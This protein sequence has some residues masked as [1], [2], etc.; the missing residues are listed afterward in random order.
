VGSGVLH[1][2]AE[3]CDALGTRPRATCIVVDDNTHAAAGRMVGELL[4]AAGHDVYLSNLTRHGGTNGTS[5]HPGEDAA[6]ALALDLRRDTGLLLAVGSGTVTDVTRFVAART[7]LPF[8]S[9]ATAPSVDAYTSVTSPM[10]RSGLKTTRWGVQARFVLADTDVLAAAPP[11]LI[12]SGLGDTVAKLVARCDWRLADL[13]TDS[14]YCEEIDR[15]VLVSVHAAVNQSAAIG[16]ALPE[17]VGILAESLMVSGAAMAMAGNTWPASGAEHFISHYLEM[18]A[19]ERN[20]PDHLHGTKVGVASVVTSLVWQR[21]ASRLAA[22]DPESIDADEVWK[23]RRKPG[24][25]GRML[26]QTFGPS[27]GRLFSSN[28]VARVG[29]EAIAARRLDTWKA[30]WGTLC[31]I[32][33]DT[34]SPD[35]IVTWL[36]EAG[37]PALPAEIGIDTDELRAT[38][39]GA[40]EV[41]NRPSVLSAAEDLGWLDE[42]IDEVVETTATG[43]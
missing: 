24:E 35:R 10:T 11:E 2:V 40:C 37:G 23:T 16:R 27:A 5:V 25:I 33:G 43:L 15:A 12:S 38:L 42:V 14:R 29:N 32:S 8:A 28:T 41:R 26:R 3:A 17:A 39:Y 13:V 19:M 31:R 9:V 7:N 6:G 36:R 34:P 30:N 20:E 4:R 21:F 22:I 1:D 18:R